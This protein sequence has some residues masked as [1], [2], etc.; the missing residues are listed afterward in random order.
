MWGESK[1]FSFI[2]TSLSIRSQR[3]A[4]SVQAGA[5][6]ALFF[7]GCKPWPAAQQL[8]EAGKGAGSP[9]GFGGIS[10][11]AFR[12]IWNIFSPYFLFESS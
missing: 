11:N 8:P 7:G 10:N 5:S 9:V 3:V 4:G 6:A 12:C 1:Y 2:Q